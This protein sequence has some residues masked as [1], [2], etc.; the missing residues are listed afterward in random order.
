[1]TNF[2]KMMLKLAQTIIKHDNENTDLY[3][4]ICD[5]GLT[6]SMCPIKRKC[7]ED[8]GNDEQHEQFMKEINEWLRQEA[9]E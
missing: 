8:G 2:E 6:C 1:M 3:S 7:E 5:A 4:V 9:V